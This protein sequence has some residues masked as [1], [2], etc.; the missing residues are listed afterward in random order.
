MREAGRVDDVG[1]A[2]QR[3]PELA[4]DLGDLE[5]V[6]EAVADE[7]IVAGLDHLRLRR[8]PPQARGVHQA[9]PVAGE[10][11]AVSPLVH[12][13]LADPALAVGRPVRHA[14]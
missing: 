5:R 9:R 11:V 8:E 3:R 6:G 13:V 7:V 1:A 4:P 14:A 12:G 10:V 2:P